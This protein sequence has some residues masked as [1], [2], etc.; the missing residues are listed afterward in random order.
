M[1]TP[2]GILTSKLWRQQRLETLAGAAADRDAR[3]VFEDDDAVAFEE[4]LKF[5]DA[6]KV[7]DGRTMC[8]EELRRVEALLQLADA[9]AK[10]MCLSADVQVQIIAHR[11]DPI[12]FGGLDK[13]DPARGLHRHAGDRLG[14]E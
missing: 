14:P 2:K 11:F 4:R 5:F 10:H 3:A 13:H 8:A 7:D 1:K 6:V 12:D 9:A